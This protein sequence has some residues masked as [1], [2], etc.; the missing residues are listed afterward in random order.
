MYTN[1][2]VLCMNVYTHISARH[3][4]GGP[5]EMFPIE[6]KGVLY[7]YIHTHTIMNMYSTYIHTHTRTLYKCI[8]TQMYVIQIH[9]LQV[10]T[11]TYV[12]IHRHVQCINIYARVHS[13]IKYMQIC[14]LYK[15][16]RTRTFINIYIQM[17]TLYKYIRTHFWQL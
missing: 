2:Y 1:K 6:D 11:H 4:W 12:R 15:Y 10:Y 5:N 9:I 17:Y 14:T 8:N 13:E 3:D 7:K 16:I